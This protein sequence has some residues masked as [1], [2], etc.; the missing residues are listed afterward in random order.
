MQID[1]LCVGHASYDLVFSVAKHPEPDEKTS[2]R[3]FAG[4][5]GGPAA[6]AAV[7]VAKLGYRSAFVGY[8]G[9]DL[10]GQQH[11]QELTALGVATSFVVRGKWPTPLS[12]ILVKPDGRRSVVN[13][14]GETPLL[15]A[16]PE[17]L[18]DCRPGVILFDGHEPL[19][20]DRLLRLAADNGA[21]TV[22]DAGS[23][24]RGTRELV[25]RVDHVVAS[26]KFAA[27]FTG[28]RDPRAALS[29]LADVAA[30]VVITR[31]EKGLVWKNRDGSG[32][33]GSF[34]LEAID[35]TGAGDAFH[36]AYAAGLA[37]GKRGLE[38]LTF[39]SA[40]GALTCTKYGARLGIP[41]AAD[42]QRLLQDKRPA[43]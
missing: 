32:G 14:R 31:G 12:A 23:V 19:L 42:V 8:L 43:D 22:L 37:A 10:Y 2:A 4:C 5:G 1:V 39:A 26:E 41:D 6:N 27:D 16:L 7:T 9:N 28:C 17:R 40:V 15:Q 20:S 33:L 24:H 36:G 35:T 21:S 11:F 18:T 13:Y 34:P 3:L 25:S 29:R 30:C 38:L